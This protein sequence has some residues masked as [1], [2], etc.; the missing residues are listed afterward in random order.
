MRKIRCW[1]FC[2]LALLFLVPPHLSASVNKAD[3]LVGVLAKRST[4]QCLQQWQ[5]LA[6]YLNE[7]IPEND[8]IIVPLS[9]GR[10]ENAVAEKSVDFVATNPAIYVALEKK[11]RTTRIVTMETMLLGIHRSQ[12]GGVLF[13]RKDRTDIRE[14]A[15]LKGKKFMAVSPISF[16]GWLTSWRYLKDQGIKPHRDFKDLRFG[17]SHD[18]VVLAVQKGEVD[19]G[20]VR[21]GILELMDLEGK[22]N[23]NDFHVIDDRRGTSSSVFMH[24]TRLYPEWAFAMLADT[25]RK[26]AER[27]TVSLLNMPQGIVISSGTE[28]SATWTIPLDYQV[29]HQCLQEL[30]IS[31]YERYGIV[32]WKH[33]V[34]QHLVTLLAIFVVLIGAWLTTVYFLTLNRRLKASAVSLDKELA[35]NAIM[36]GRLQ[37]FKQTLDQTLDSV[38]MFEPESLKYIYANRGAVKQVGYSLSE[39]LDMTVLDL[40]PNYNEEEYRKLLAPLQCGDKKSLTFI[41]THRTREGVDIPVEIVQQHVTL[42]EGEDRFVS[43]VR[44]ISDRISADR[45][46]DKMQTQLLHAQKL[47]SVG[48][49]AAGI[50]HEINTPT[51]F[52]GTNIDFMAEAIQDISDFIEEVQK[53]ADSAPQEI[54]D[55]MRDALEKVDWEYLAEELP[56]AI[57]QSQDGVK[58]VTSIVLAMKEF[59]HPSSREK[60][61]QDLN[62]I[63]ETTVTVARNEW[64]YVA[65]MELD[66]DPNLP[67]IPLLTDEMGQVILNMLVNGAHAIAEKLGDNPDGVKGRIT[68]STKKVEDKVELRIS[69]NGQGITEKVKLRIFD[70]FF[71]TKKVGKGTGQGLAISHDV[72]VEK[73]HGTIQVDSTPGEGTTFIIR[74]PLGEE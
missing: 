72:I 56:C 65:D 37:Q 24:T 22:I 40:M 43:I 2:V 11:Y 26:L 53:I 13:T 33:L 19:A 6:D 12:F 32:T 30:H 38:F 8:F 55:R 25:D 20:A 63:I 49:L 73:H 7:A 50:A 46:K 54:G 14:P 44:D 34:D 3:I 17:Y 52:I 66:L 60:V 29:V 62:H 45:A 41:T 18:T 5:P 67:Q 69:D 15:D 1:L 58:R 31:P 16:G 9:F 10:I 36:E 27:V 23:L 48:Q 64:K 42:S 57:S 51:Q 28:N 39:L 74:L 4:E 61:P 35:T 71:T 47:E 70:P 59:S 21:S 68:V